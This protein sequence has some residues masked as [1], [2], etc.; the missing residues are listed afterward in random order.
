MTAIT[1][2]DAPDPDVLKV[3]EVAGILRVS[4]WAVYERIKKGELR[5]V[6]VGRAVRVPRVAL[7][8]F[9]GAA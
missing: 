7:D 5:A 3:E 9:M 2:V 4:T 1:H 6:H 8:E